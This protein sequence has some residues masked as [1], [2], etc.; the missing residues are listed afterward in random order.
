MATEAIPYCPA[1]ELKNRETTTALLSVNP[2]GLVQSQN[3]IPEILFITS[4]PPR[5]CGIAT[6]SQDLVDALNNQFENSFTCSVCALESETE[7]HLY[8]THPKYI[9]N[10]DERNA[11]AKIAFKINGDENIK[12]VVMQHEFGFFAEKEKEFKYLFNSISKPI[13]FV[14]HTVLPKPNAELRAKVQDMA[15]TAASII[16]MTTNAATILITDYNVSAYKITVIP[17]GTHLVSPLD[18]KKVKKHY[19]LSDR[20]VLSTFGLLGSS[21]SI[22]TTLEALPS[23]IKTHP[24]V[25]FLVLGKTHPSIVKQEGEQ[26][27]K[28]LEEKVAEL[29]IEKH[30]RFVNEYLQLPILLEYLQISDIYLFTSKDPV[31]AVS[32][33]FSY[34]VSSGCPVISTPIPHAKEVLSDNNGIIID[35]ENAAQLSKAIVSLLD[36][37]KLRIEIS[38]ISFHKMASTVWQNSAIA[39]ALLF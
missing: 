21:K 19:Q 32:G 13:V 35:F 36:N 12:L 11:F 20:K 26:Y 14:F 29:G 9:L 4:F 22:E 2:N 39:H 25:L 16:V 28:M 34:A 33:T 38:S 27:R 6:Y 1:T 37:E 17:H 18:R 23:V 31:Q 5:E 30:V 15:A 10:T 3:N 7:Q 24:D 8:S